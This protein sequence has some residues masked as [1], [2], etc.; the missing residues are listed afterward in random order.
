MLR[1]DEACRN[2]VYRSYIETLHY[3]S[4]NV[5]EFVLIKYIHKCVNLIEFVNLDLIDELG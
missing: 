2:Y 4:N 5:L 1:L 3:L